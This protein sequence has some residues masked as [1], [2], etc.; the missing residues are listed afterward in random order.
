MK[1][2]T[3][4]KTLP[5]I[6]TLIMIIAQT[7]Q[8]TTV[9]AEVSIHKLESM[10]VRGGIYT[11]YI[12]ADN[13]YMN[14][15]YKSL[16]KY[17]EPPSINVSININGLKKWA[18]Y[19]LTNR[20]LL[21][22]EIQDWKI[23]PLWIPKCIK[24]NDEIPVYNYETTFKCIVKN[25]TTIILSHEGEKLIYDP[26]T[27]VLIEGEIR[28]DGYGKL[29]LKLNKTN[30]KIRREYFDDLYFDWETLTLNLMK[31]E[32]EYANILKVYSIGKSV[33]GREIWCCEIKASESEDG[34]VLIDGG[35]HGSE[36]IGVKV[37]YS[38]LERVL[39]EYNELQSIGVLK[40]L[41]LI[42]IPMLNPDGVEMSKYSPPT[43]SIRLKD[44]RC[45]ANGVDLNRNF[46]YEWSA[47]GSPLY[48]STVYRGEVAESEPEVKALKDLMQKRKIIFYVN[49]HS[50]VRQIIIP[51]YKVNPY[52]NVYANI[53]SILSNIFG[54]EIV[55]GGIYGGS[56]N[57]CLMAKGGPALSLIIEL[58]GGGTN[59]LNVDWFLFYNPV[60]DVEIRK[61]TILSYQ[62]T[63]QILLNAK[64]WRD[65][66]FE[67]T[68][69]SLPLE[70]IKI[71]LIT[72]III[73]LGLTIYVKLRKSQG[74]INDK[75]S[76]TKPPMSVEAKFTT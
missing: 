38:I 47:G 69:P 35:M 52:L 23:Y 6:F 56:A 44:G 39:S 68:L 24:L 13:G 65:M 60:D 72:I 30:M 75:R 17:T 19:S 27:G 61:L 62:A 16:E 5:L 21:Y 73:I 41:T 8:I 14:V 15:T 66:I 54:F 76:P 31:L 64:K 50:G 67:K 1:S 42:I 63:I 28:L 71:T 58:Y 4:T 12:I 29:Q 3:Q 34:V 55:R 32:K 40:R 2:Y 70:S 57:W 20:K 33:L 10:D 26:F 49:L 22:G 36:V 45:N 43:P 59:A 9:T 37:A 25:E 46:N 48:N 7:P 11:L 74:R 51:A 53:T 18:V